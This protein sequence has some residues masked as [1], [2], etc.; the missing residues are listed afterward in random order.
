MVKVV[1]LQNLWIP[2]FFQLHYQF[3]ADHPFAPSEQVLL[4]WYSLHMQQA[5]GETQAASEPQ[6]H[7]TAADMVRSLRANGLL[8]LHHWSLD[9]YLFI[10]WNVIHS[11]PGC[12]VASPPCKL[13]SS[14]WPLHKNHLSRLRFTS[15]DQ[16][17]VFHAHF[18]SH[19]PNA[20]FA[21][22]LFGHLLISRA[23]YH[24]TKWSTFVHRV[25]I[26]CAF[27]QCCAMAYWA[28]EPAYPSP[29]T[30]PQHPFQINSWPEALRK[31]IQR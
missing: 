31:L 5:E 17:N 21:A 1:V 30:Q 29:G 6:A 8:F 25:I 26:I 20:V 10:H 22:F 16:S 12:C 28:Q 15:L 9:C 3:S 14:F 18:N 7:P 19:L 23:S 27:K 13:F 11:A 24:L 2:S 4:Y